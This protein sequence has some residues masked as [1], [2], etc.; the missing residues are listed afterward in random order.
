MRTLKSRCFSSSSAPAD[1]S[2]EDEAPHTTGNGVVAEVGG[3]HAPVPVLTCDLRVRNSPSRVQAAVDVAGEDGDG[4]SDSESD[5]D[6]DDVRVTIG[7]IKTG[8]PQ[9]T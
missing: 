1:A 2:A 9:Y 4:D 5:D 7:D 3:V 6:D 8:A